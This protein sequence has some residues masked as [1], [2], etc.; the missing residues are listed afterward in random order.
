MTLACLKPSQRA[1]CEC[2]RCK[3]NYMAPFKKTKHRSTLHAFNSLRGDHRLSW[4]LLLS[5]LGAS[6][7]LFRDLDFSSSREI[8]TLSSHWS[9]PITCLFSNYSNQSW[10]LTWSVQKY[11]SYVYHQSTKLVKYLDWPRTN[12]FWLTFRCIQMIKLDRELAPNCVV[13]FTP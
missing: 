12:I 5:P 13:L 8:H 4:D 11:R 10:Q 6:F 2:Q 3:I 7:S 1:K 9:L